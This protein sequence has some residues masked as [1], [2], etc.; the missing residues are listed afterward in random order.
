MSHLLA[1]LNPPSRKQG[2]SNSGQNRSRFT[3]T[4]WRWEVNLA[5]ITRYL[6]SKHQTVPAVGTSVERFKVGD[7][8]TSL[9]APYWLCGKACRP[10]PNDQI[11]E[12]HIDGQILTEG[13]RA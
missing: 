7:R 8:V 10:S 2:P 12:R 1:L 5:E 4:N 11:L 9:F 13:V 3:E 6:L